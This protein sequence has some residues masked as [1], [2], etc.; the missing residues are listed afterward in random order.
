M[1]SAES[2]RER[3]ASLE[4]IVEDGIIEAG[5]LEH[6]LLDER[7]ALESRDATALG[8]AADEKRLR[9]ARLEALEAARKAAAKSCVADQEQ[10]GPATGHDRSEAM[11]GGR[12][13]NF[14][15]IVGRCNTLN[16]TNGAIIRLRRQ[17]ISDALR[18]VSGTAE[19][20]YGPSGAEPSSR[21]RRALA[22]I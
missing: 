21:P 15:A 6:A 1:T 20:T 9:V 8:Q 7:R 4:R 19:E 13:Q 16:M 11:T 18:A 5:A 3:R 17:Q 22:S 12:W 14:L 10:A 2:L